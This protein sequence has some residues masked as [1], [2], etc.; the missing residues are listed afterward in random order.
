M[1]APEPFIRPEDYPGLSQASADHINT[2]VRADW[3]V[4]FASKPELRA[5]DCQDKACVAMHPYTPA[6]KAQLALL[7]AS[8]VP[9]ATQKAG[10]A[11]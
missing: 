7:F 2:H 4:L 10:E 1:S 9:P 6:Q 3:R 5:C 11:A 8:P